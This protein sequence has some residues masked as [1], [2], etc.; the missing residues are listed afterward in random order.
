MCKCCTGG[1]G[2][3][4]RYWWGCVMVGLDEV[5]SNIN[6]AVILQCIVFIV[7]AHSA[8]FSPMLCCASKVAT[9]RL[10]RLPP[11]SGQHSIRR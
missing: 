3:V 7:K 10:P 8:A 1:H 11:G 6:D 9:C 5:F 4:G 2:L